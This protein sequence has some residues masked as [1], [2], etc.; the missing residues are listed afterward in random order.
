MHDGWQPG[1][2][3]ILRDPLQ[4]RS[5]RVYTAIRGDTI[6]N[7]PGWPYSVVEDSD[8]IVA[9]YLPQGTKLWRWDIVEQRMR[10]PRV[11]IGDSLRLLFPG[12]PY[13][14]DL[15][16]E[17]GSGP[18]PWVR[19]FFLGE[20]SH[21]YDVELS[22]VGSGRLFD[23]KPSPAEPVT[24]HFYGW[25]VDIIAPFQ[26][27]EL[28]FD[29]TDEVLDIVVRPDRSYAINDADQM[30]H[31]VARGI[32][33]REEADLLHAH[34]REVIGL[35]EAAK[36]PFDDTW[37]SWQASPDLGLPEAPAGWQFLRLPDAEWG[38][39]HHPVNAG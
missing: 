28:G 17:S 5:T 27:T 37:T 38:A 1:D 6:A 7:L 24:G 26:G 32:Y 25:K 15:F 4:T 36:P 8:E 19:Y 34:V 31:F 14:V 22:R 13:H 20:P 11:T 30:E 35:I 10:Q 9:L 21:G 29:V 12:K 16:F 18:A 39:I 33:T 3:I 2:N 23:D